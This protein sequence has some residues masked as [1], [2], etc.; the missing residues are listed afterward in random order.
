MPALEL[1]PILRQHR[2]FAILSSL[3]L[4]LLYAEEGWASYVFWP[5][6]PFSQGVW[7]VV[8]I[9]AVAFV[10]YLAS[11]LIPPMLV[12]D[13]WDHPRAWGVLINVMAWSAGITVLVNIVIFALLLYLVNEDLV[14]TYNLLRDIYIYTLAALL[15]FHG[16]LLYVR[17][18]AFLYQTPDFVQPIKV[19]AAS[20]GIAFV[21]FLVAGFLFT[22]D[23]H[24][25]DSTPLSQQGL[26]GIHVYVRALYLLTLVLASY[27]WHLRWIADH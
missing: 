13:T 5:H 8:L 16:L 2:P 17:Y 4:A 18:M 22:L 12:S 21:I 25:L 9:A 1:A 15:F 10:G 6:R 24:R 3:G 26:L 7:L 11:F 20:A 14:A 19:V 23:I 27:A